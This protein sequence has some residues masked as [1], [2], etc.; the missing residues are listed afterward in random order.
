[1][2]QQHRGVRER[3]NILFQTAQKALG[4]PFALIVNLLLFVELAN[5]DANKSPVIIDL[6]CFGAFPD[7]V[8]QLQQAL[9]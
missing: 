8:F 9:V 4:L 3:R 2:V 1:V 6:A 5:N 7:P